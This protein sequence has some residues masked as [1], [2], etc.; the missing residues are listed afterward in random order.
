MQSLL[1]AHSELTSF[2]ESHFFDRYFTCF[3]GRA[4]PLLVRNPAPRVQEFL[5]ENDEEPTEA[6]R[7]FQASFRARFQ[8][9]WPLASKPLL[10]LQT[11]SV[12]R[13]LLLVLDQLTLRRGNAG[14]VEKTPR[15]LR[16]IP[17]LES[18]TSTA[19]SPR[20]RT[21][22]VHVIRNGLEV[23]AS[24]QKASQAWERPYDVA[25]C[26]ERW[27]A[28]VGFSLG[29]FGKPTDHFVFY[30]E[31]TARP[32]AAMS[33]LCAHLGLD[34]EPEILQRQGDDSQRLVT[35][36][37]TWKEDI[38]RTIRPSETSVQSLTAEQRA[39]ALQSLRH[40]QYEE[41]AKRALAQ[42]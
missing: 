22:F 19:P 41:L 17:L 6:S 14:W 21:D 15:H 25:A 11:R 38:G 1:A 20:G 27:N 2:T 7:W 9:K 5:L 10:P 8:A 42:G 37:E 35:R 3:P 29:R 4:L 18:L 36:E 12:A 33:Q 28:D 30:E 31:L 32:E 39:W 40:E 13:R 16:Y 24:L 34:W 26:V 23:V